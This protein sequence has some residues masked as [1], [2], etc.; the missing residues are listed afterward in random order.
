MSVYQSNR[1]TGGS[2]LNG[3][4]SNLSATQLY[5]KAIQF[6]YI[7]EEGNFQISKEALKVFETSHNKIAI[8]CIT[9]CY[10]TGKSFLMN[11]LVGEQAAFTVDP[12]VNACTRGLWFYSEPITIEIE[13][14]I[15]DIYVMDTEGLG[16]V[17]KSQNYDIKIFT[18][19]VLLSSFLIYN[20]VGVIDEQSITNL[21][22]V[23]NLAKNI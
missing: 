11:Q 17:D 8:I 9:G 15:F 14:E 19:S 10:R 16:G 12:S 2:N 20:Q 21:S 18:L 23:T 5:Q 7:D 1:V 22:L 3:T 6:I 13:N 4:A